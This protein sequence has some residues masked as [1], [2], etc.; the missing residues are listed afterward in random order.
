[1]KL[2]LSIFPVT[3]HPVCTL[4]ASVQPINVVHA[5]LFLPHPDRQ[6]QLDITYPT[7]MNAVV[8][9]EGV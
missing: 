1:M 6:L 7:K 5:A 8:E 3:A 9:V 2:P 4:N